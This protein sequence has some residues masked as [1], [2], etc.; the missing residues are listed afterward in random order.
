MS[1]NKI[2]ES[3]CAGNLEGASLPGQQRRT[4]GEAEITGLEQK[5]VKGAAWLKRKY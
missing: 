3:P 1:F 2:D 4:S 5:A